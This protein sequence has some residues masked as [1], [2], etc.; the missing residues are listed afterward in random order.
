MSQ[1]LNNRYVCPTHWHP[2]CHVIGALSISTGVRPDRLGFLLR[3]CLL[4]L[5]RT[6]NSGLILYSTVHFPEL[7]FILYS[8]P[9]LNRGPLNYKLNALPSELYECDKVPR[10]TLR[11]KYQ[12]DTYVDEAFVWWQAIFYAPSKER[13]QVSIFL[14]NFHNPCQEVSAVNEII[15][16]YISVIASFL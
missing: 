4:I 16:T 6:D 15:I 10:K 5:V 2:K 7:L 14:P 13:S 9:G 8:Y 3:W 11:K 12:A 1:H